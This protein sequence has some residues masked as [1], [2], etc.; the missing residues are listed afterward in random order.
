VLTGGTIIESKRMDSGKGIYHKMI[1]SGDQGIFHLKFEQ[2]YFIDK[3]KA[4]VVTFTAERSNFD[5]YITTAEKIL[6]SFK[7]N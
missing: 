7:L 4:Y 3:A 6:S 1:F 2:Y 5:N